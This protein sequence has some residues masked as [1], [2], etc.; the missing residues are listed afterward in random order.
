MRA[1]MNCGGQTLASLPLPAD[2]TAEGGMS[3]CYLRTIARA[4]K[5]VLHV[6]A[7]QLADAEVEFTVEKE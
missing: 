5:A 3:G 2:A 7:P 6:S 1:G 4:G